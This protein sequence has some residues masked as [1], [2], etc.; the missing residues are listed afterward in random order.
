MKDKQV[1]ELIRFIRFP[2]MVMVVM[3]HAHVIELSMGGVKYSFEFDLYPIYNNIS[4]FISELVC[5]IS[6]PIFY[7]IAG[8]LFYINIFE[9]T[10]KEYI[11]KIYKRTNTLV[12]P[13]M[14]WNL[15][16]IVLFF[17]VQTIIPSFTSGANKLI[18]DYNFYDWIRCFWNFHDGMPICYQLWFIRDLYIVVLLSPII[19]YAIKKCNFYFVLLMGLLWLFRI[20]SGIIGISVIAIFFFSLGALISINKYN[21]IGFIQKNTTLVYIMSLLLI[22]VEMIFFNIKDISL[23]S[24]VIKDI[25]YNLCIIGMMLSFLSIVIFL[26]QKKQLQTNSFFHD[27]NF[28]IY[29][30]HAMPLALIMKVL[31]KYV[32]PIS[33][34]GIIF[35]YF[36]APFLT[37]I[38][39]LLIFASLKK[40]F[41]QFTAFISGSRM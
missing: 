31:V 11:R 32:H 5:R 40:F 13:Y 34:I 9:Y 41:P 37:I 16:V 15:A 8:Y 36:I 28:F 24:D 33:D 19:Y 38:L 27:S 21:F 14:F 30:F 29:A 10:F 35:I 23:L 12:F 3:I 18:S 7:I 17:L 20:D 22:I 4:Y 6:V 2:L 26:L 1:S 39:G 25:L